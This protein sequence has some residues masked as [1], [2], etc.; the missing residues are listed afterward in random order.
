MGYVSKKSFLKIFFK[1]KFTSQILQT[2]KF[3]TL[4]WPY[5]CD[6]SFW[7]RDL[8]FGTCIKDSIIETAE[9]MVKIC[10]TGLLKLNFETR[11]KKR[12]FRFLP[13]ISAGHGW[14]WQFFWP[15]SKSLG[16]Q[17]WVVIPQNVKKVKI[18][19][20]YCSR[21]SNVINMFIGNYLPLFILENPLEIL[22]F[23]FNK[24]M[25]RSY[26]L[27]LFQAFEAKRRQRGTNKTRKVLVNMCWPILPLFPYPEVRSQ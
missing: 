6:Y 21:V 11:P 19:A 20:P 8:K 26:I 16:C 5:P 12:I 4:S 22:H 14:S 3:W 24:L 18:T 9:K 17:G 25:K 13:K 10:Q 23:L 15:I 27:A 1:I 7:L 2:D